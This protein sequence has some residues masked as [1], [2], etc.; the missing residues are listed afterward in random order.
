VQTFSFGNNAVKRFKMSSFE[1]QV[2]ALDKK[3]IVSFSDTLNLIALQ[4]Q[5]KMSTVCN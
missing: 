3:I 5:L 4:L 1:S 2:W